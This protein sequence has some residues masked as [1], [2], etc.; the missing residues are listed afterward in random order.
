M[1]PYIL[2]ITFMLVLWIQLEKRKSEKNSKKESKEFWDKEY[3]S[4]FVR[5]KDISNLDYITIPLESLPFS[6]TLDKD[7]NDIQN[8]IKN[9]ATKKIL[10]LS[11]YSNTDLKLTFGTANL[12][13]LITY[14]QNYA[15]L[16]SSL[17]QWG[18]LLHKIGEA[19]KAK[20]VLRYGIDC[21]SDISGNYILLAKLYAKDNEPDKIKDLISSA[22]TIQSILKDSL[23]KSLNTIY[24]ESSHVQK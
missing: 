7:L 16:I 5:K 11:S 22:Q 13:T 4:N 10:N 21:N 12:E 18:E 20:T 17:Y 9:L 8:M 14:D 19:D 15:Q 6:E 2:I 24:E 3:N 23:L 1:L